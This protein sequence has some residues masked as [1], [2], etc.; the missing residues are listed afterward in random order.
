M[1]NKNKELWVTKLLSKLSYTFFLMSIISFLSYFVLSKQGINESSA[2]TMINIIS[3]VSYISIILLFL[4]LIFFIINKK[5]SFKKIKKCISIIVY[6][7]IS[8][9]I[10][11][12]VNT[13]YIISLGV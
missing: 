10:L 13:I 7:L 2:Y 8:F 9:S 3:I 5:V 12:L 4:N 11:I 1:F 6:I